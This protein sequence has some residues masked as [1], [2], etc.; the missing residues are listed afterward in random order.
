MQGG[1]QE[2]GPA[3]EAVEWLK[4]L[5]RQ[6]TWSVGELWS[7]WCFP[8]RLLL[9]LG[10][11]RS[12]TGQDEKGVGYQ[13]DSGLRQEAA[14]LQEETDVPRVH[15]SFS[16]VQDAPGELTNIWED[17]RRQ[18]GNCSPIYSSFPFFKLPGRGSF[19]T[20]SWEGWEVQ[21]VGTVLGDGQKSQGTAS[22]LP[23]HLSAVGDSQQPD[24]QSVASCSEAIPQ[25]P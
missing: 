24:T 7:P 4:H 13:P 10:L 3:K 6:P 9:Q 16:E 20:F 25:L 2:R 1:R 23:G 11:I 21:L 19:A 14:C 22:G 18:W 17:N 5:A 15:P 8:G 12:D